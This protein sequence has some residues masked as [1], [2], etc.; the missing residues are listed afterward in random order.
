MLKQQSSTEDK[1]EKYSVKVVKFI[2]T[3]CTDRKGL[4]LFFKFAREI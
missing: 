4:P 2:K 3:I 1:K